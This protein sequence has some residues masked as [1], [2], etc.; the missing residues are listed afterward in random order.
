MT[1][2]I[3]GA[4]AGVG[5]ATARVF[6]RRGASVALIA[7]GT[8]GLEAAAE[9]VHAAGG[10]ASVIV[11]DVSDADAV[12]QAAEQ[13]ETDLGPIAVW[14]NNAMV[15]VF[16][17]VAE[18]TADE[19]RRVTEVTYLGYVHGTL[20]ALARMR[21]RDEGTIVQVS[22]A[23]AHRSIPLQAAYCGA[24]HAIKGF[25]ESLR[26]ELLHDRSGVHVTRVDL[27]ALNTPQFD[28]VRN[29]LP[30]RSRP[31]GRI[32]QPELAAD[33][34]AWAADHAPRELHVGVTTAAVLAANR[35]APSLVDRF[36]AVAAWDGQHTG[37]A[38]GLGT[39]DNLVEPLPGDRGS[40][41]RFDH[42]A[43]STSWQLTAQ[44]ALRTLAS[45]LAS[46]V[47]RTRR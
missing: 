24:K 17:P 36:L 15:S 7:R 20:A 46:L 31:A 11:C 13:A 2:V 5:R 12:E 6:G 30:G 18:L 47:R 25:S 29:R 32:Y 37:E 21:S 42:E 34:I 4:S 45:R 40:R 33:A 3:T 1:V 28:W 14:V 8:D 43:H 27:P 9:E 38:A 39:P 23:L 19:V 26:C 41:G 22:S 44:L 10:R 16:S 35:V